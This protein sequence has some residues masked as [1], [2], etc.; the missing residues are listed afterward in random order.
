MRPQTTNNMKG[1]SCSMMYSRNCEAFVVSLHKLYDQWQTHICVHITFVD[2][3]WT[4]WVRNT[5]K[6]VTMYLYAVFLMPAEFSSSRIN[7][8]S[9]RNQYFSL[10]RKNY[11]T[12]HECLKLHVT[13]TSVSRCA[14]AHLQVTQIQVSDHNNPMLQQGCSVTLFHQS[15]SPSLTWL[16]TNKKG[17]LSSK[18]VQSCVNSIRE[19]NRTVFSAKSVMNH[20]G[21]MRHEKK[22]RNK[23]K[24]QI[25][26]RCEK[27]Q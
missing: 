5:R 21:K 7:N 8:C 3:L 15:F 2:S 23:W 1:W 18:V 17:Y 13:F 24:C 19:G 27:Q 22:K 20:R 16:K 10:Q 6:T 26:H 14:L 4:V 11:R 9:P 25:L 12:H